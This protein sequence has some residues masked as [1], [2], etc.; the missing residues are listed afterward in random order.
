M[1]DPA[2]LIRRG[3][4][5]WI[6]AIAFLAGSACGPATSTAAPPGVVVEPTTRP[7]LTA[8]ETTAAA[9]APTAEAAAG[10][11]IFHNG[12]I[13]T[14]DEAQ[15]K[16][17]AIHIR[18]GKIVSVDDEASI[19]AEAS[20]GTVV[21]DLGGLTLMPGFIDSH[22][23][24]FHGASAFGRND[25][26]AQDEALS[27]GITSIGELWSDQALV[28]HLEDLAASGGLRVR[29]T[30]YLTPYNDGCGNIY[31]EDWYRAYPPGAELGRNLRLGGIKIYT[32]GGGCNAPAVSFEYAGGE[33]NGDLYFTQEG[34]NRVVA[35]FHGQGYQ[36]AI[37]AIGDRA[38]EQA[39]NA[40]ADAQAG[41]P[42]TIRH[43]IEHT[44]VIR[45]ELMPRFQE[46]DVVGVL[47]GGYP[48][49][50]L[51][52]RDD[53]FK[54][55]T[56]DAYLAWEWPRRALLAAAPEAHIA[57]HSDAYGVRPLN[58]FE[59]L[60][61]MVTRR[62]V[63]E[64]GTVCEPPPALAA[65]T[66]SVEQA[67]KAMILEGAYA[68]G[69]EAD[70]GSLTPGKLADIVLVTQS[71][72]EVPADELRS[73]GVVMTMVGGRVEYCAEGYQTLCPEEVPIAAPP[74]VRPGVFHDEF[75]GALGP[76]W[77]WER[78]DAS[79]WSLTATPGW[80]RLGL[81]A[82][83]YLTTPPSNVLLRP[84]PSGDFEVQTTLRVTPTRNFEIAGLIVTFG[85]DSVLQFGR[86]FC[87][88]PGVCTGGGYYFDSVQ[89]GASAGSNFAL[90]GLAGSQHVL[91]LQKQGT[92][93]TASYLTVDG[94]WIPIGS[95]SV[96]Q[97]PASVGLIAAQ[98]PAPGPVAEFDFFEMTAQP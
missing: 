2:K 40:V 57:Y 12:V 34:L 79:A 56:P 82:G 59:N 81:S 20:P 41:G 15:P 27:F 19:L 75:D 28:S 32:D 42:G 6:L 14:M 8:P 90:P 97:A 65:N 86:A 3:G 23:H 38:I 30:V 66:I 24:L 44:A 37:H 71:P 48:T 78:E 36:L 9:P 39:L 84:A 83:G 47:F 80:L 46:L 95:H 77:T 51:V 10:D 93:Y 96:A 67:L 61:G 13:L 4:P 92:T 7:I 70:L 64:D 94:E 60:Y 68:L 11:F 88:V 17:S 89:S 29:E 76:G 52:N 73:I 55:Y 74:A 54:Y 43:R 49:C 87:D 53:S 63:A 16:A 25:T 62:E 33:G 18:G 1:N 72:L 31:D 58:P 35:D 21:V 26:T 5:G 85:D 45:P 50:W 91:R 69:Q 22:T 98:A